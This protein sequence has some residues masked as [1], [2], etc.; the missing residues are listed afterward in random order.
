[1]RAPH[2]LVLLSLAAVAAA[3]SM[4]PGPTNEPDDPPFE[5]VQVG[6]TRDDVE[7]ILGVDR[8]FVPAGGDLTADVLVRNLGLD[9]VLWQGGGCDLQGEF[10]ITPIKPLA[11][12]P[13]GPVW[14]GDKGVIQQLALPDAYTSR[15]ATPPEFA[16]RDVNWGCTSDLRFHELRPGEETTARIIW[17]AST[18]AGS[19]VPGGDYRV[20]VRFPFVGR[21]LA[22]PPPDFEVQRDVKPITAELLIS[23][24]DHPPLPPAVE[25]MNAV[26]EHPAFTAWLEVHPRQIWNSTALRWIDGAWVV[27]VRYQPDK[28]LSARVDP[29]TGIVTLAD[30]LDPLTPG[31]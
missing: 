24:E 31:G 7:V 21:G 3:C 26:L 17:V 16:H 5:P 23:V 28:M 8:G 22:G 29:A 1:M 14:A 19:P 10:A 27:Q 2:L 30:G 15:P 13:A 9:T 18:V 4:L 20:S 25:A 6:S 11:A 12:A